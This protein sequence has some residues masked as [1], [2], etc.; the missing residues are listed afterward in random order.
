MI[1]E[2]QQRILL[3]IM[4]RPEHER[5]ELSILRLSISSALCEKAI[6]NHLPVMMRDGLLT[7]TRPG[8]GKPYSFEILPKAHD[9]LK[10]YDPSQIP[11]MF[12]AFRTARQWRSVL[13]SGGS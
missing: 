2:T 12:D 8:P 7:Y 13:L 1:N 3:A 11:R 5:R 9:E 6:R 4:D 10:H